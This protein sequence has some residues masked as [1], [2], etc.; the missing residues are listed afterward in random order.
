MI[1]A[2]IARGRRRQPHD[3]GNVAVEF[4]YLLPLLAVLLVG[5]F[6]YGSMVNQQAVLEGA[7][8]A[9]AEYARTK[10]T[11][12]SGIKSQVTGY[13]TFSPA[14]TATVTTFCTCSDNA[15]VT[16]PTQGVADPCP[17]TTGQTDPRVFVF[18]AVQASQTFSA[19]LSW[20]WTF[21]SSLS[22]G[23]VVRIQ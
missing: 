16:C 14:P 15:T 10:P 12:T 11:D 20:T 21:P 22:A 8:R 18:V 4:A 23:T 7:T 17:A 3:G 6:D 9:G 2:R 5:S 13:A 19:I 1:A